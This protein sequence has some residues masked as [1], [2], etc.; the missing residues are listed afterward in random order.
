MTTNPPLTA[1]RL[2][3]NTIHISDIIRI[4]RKY[5]LYLLGLMILGGIL[6][7]IWAKF[8]TP[9][10]DAIALVHLDQHSSISLGSRET[11]SGAMPAKPARR[12]WQS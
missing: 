2:A 11:I 5:G 12:S 9:Q 8:Q 4:M 1:N 6:A 3:E 10:Y 7:A